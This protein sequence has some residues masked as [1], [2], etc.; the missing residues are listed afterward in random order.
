MVANIVWRLSVRNLPEDFAF[1]EIDGSSAPVWRFHQRQ[2]LNCQA[3]AC[4]FIGSPGA[5]AVGTGIRACAT[6]G[7]D[8]TGSNALNVGKVTGNLL[9]ARHQTQRTH[10]TL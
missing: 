6:P 1:V 2:P 4:I 3:R 10:H 9:V 7:P 5:G 8:A